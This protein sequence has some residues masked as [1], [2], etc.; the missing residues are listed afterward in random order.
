MLDAFILKV[1]RG[2]T[3]FY[4]G[5]REMARRVRSSTL[6][7]PHFIYPALRLCFHLNHA[8]GSSFRWLLS[9]FYIEPLFRSR[10]TAVGKAFRLYR[11][12][13]VVG[14]AKIYIGDNVNFFG[15][16]DIFSGRMFDEPELILKDR[17][18]IGHG[19]VFVVNRQIV[20]EEDVNV[21][22][23]VRFMDSD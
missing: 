22:S 4:R 11:M 9:Y 21:A 19:V 23:G 20:I 8:V 3:P 13:F 7:L 5:L 14:H 10:C 15:K 17:V 1:R 12:P 2:E 16:V 6:P 18:D